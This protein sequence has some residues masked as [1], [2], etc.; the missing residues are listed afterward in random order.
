MNGIPQDS[1]DGTSM[2]YTFDDPEAEG[3]RTTQFFD[4]LI[5]VT[6]AFERVRLEVT[7][8]EHGTT[9]QLQIARKR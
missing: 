7:P 9:L 2:L 5:A 6:R 8:S 4:M 1:F 3:R